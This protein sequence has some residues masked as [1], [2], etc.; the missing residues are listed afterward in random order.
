[1]VAKRRFAERL[2]RLYVGLALFGVSLA[3]M[4][5]ANLGLGPWDVFHQ[6][7]ADRTGLSIG[8]IVN[9]TAVVVLLL[10]IPLRQRPGL[11]TLS[12]VVLVGLFTDATLALLATPDNL[13]LRVAMLVAGILSNAV[14]TALYVGAGLGPGPRDGLMTGLAARGHSIRLVRTSIEVA[15]L[16]IGWLL[17][18]SVGVGTVLYALTIGPLV[19]VLLPKLSLPGGKP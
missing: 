3:L 9:L 14:A 18:G 19:G 8:I 5:R 12:N 6:G 10:W 17:G 16:A 4:V 13:A 15:V 1:V 11:G 7:I 2:I